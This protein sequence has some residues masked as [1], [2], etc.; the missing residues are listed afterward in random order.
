MRC[1]TVDQQMTIYCIGGS[2]VK[3]KRVLS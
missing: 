1:S 3:G 2:S